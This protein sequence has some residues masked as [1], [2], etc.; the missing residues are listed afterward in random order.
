MY[1]TDDFEVLS[2]HRD[3]RIRLTNERW[4]HILDHPEMPGQRERLIETLTDPDVV[5]ATAKDE[6]V[7]VYHRL[8]D[9][10]PVTRKYMVVVVKMLADD[11]FVLTAFFTSKRKRG[12]VIWQ[13]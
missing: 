4:S 13:K 1:E 8:Y 10:T 6:D 7:H 9:K 11:A 5:I 3:R 2:D 12:K